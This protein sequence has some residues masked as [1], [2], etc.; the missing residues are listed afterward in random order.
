MKKLCPEC[1]TVKESK[2]FIKGICKECNAKIVIP[3]RVLSEEEKEFERHID[4]DH[5]VISHFYS[6]KTRHPNIPFYLQDETG[7]T[8]EFGWNLIYQYIENCNQ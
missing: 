4:D 3:P 1:K 7:K 5:N 2:D 8:Y 6:A